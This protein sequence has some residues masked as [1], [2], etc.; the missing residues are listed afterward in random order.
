MERLFKLA[1]KDQDHLLTLDEF[2]TAFSGVPDAD[3]MFHEADTARTGAINYDQFIDII[4]P[5][6]WEIPE[7]IRSKSILNV[8]M[9][10]FG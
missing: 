2:R 7:D 9:Y 6:G 3:Q 4:A 1:D 5:M 10:G 8:S